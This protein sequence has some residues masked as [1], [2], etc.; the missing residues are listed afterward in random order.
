MTLSGNPSFLLDLEEQLA[1]SR[2]EV[3]EARRQ[4]IDLEN[5][6]SPS[7]VQHLAQLQQSTPGVFLLKIACKISRF[8]LE[9]WQLMASALVPVLLLL[10]RN[11]VQGMSS[12]T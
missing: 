9:K 11:C 1:A 5:R 3:E 7:N 10:Q 12:V 6:P 4:E 8:V 2:H